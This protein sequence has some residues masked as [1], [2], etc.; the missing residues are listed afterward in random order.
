MVQEILQNFVSFYLRK[1]NMPILPHSAALES[2]QE[3]NINKVPFL[4]V[5]L[6]NWFI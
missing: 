1:K 2:I 5:I 6:V 4:K 3:N